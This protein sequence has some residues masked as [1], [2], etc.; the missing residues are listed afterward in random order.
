MPFLPRLVGAKSATRQV[1]SDSDEEEEDS[2]PLIIFNRFAF[3]SDEL[4]GSPLPAHHSSPECCASG[5]HSSKTW[6]REAAA[7]L[8]PSRAVPK[9][10]RHVQALA[11]RKLL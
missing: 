5:L 3:L 6:I 4:G 8:C 9:K 7:V 1:F 2:S 10:C 11:P